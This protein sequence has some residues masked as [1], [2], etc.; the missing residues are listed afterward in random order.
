MEKEGYRKLL[1]PSKE[2]TIQPKIIPSSEFLEILERSR[3]E[4]REEREKTLAIA[5]REKE[6]LMR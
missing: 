2:P 3:N 1:V 4:T 5:E 6:R